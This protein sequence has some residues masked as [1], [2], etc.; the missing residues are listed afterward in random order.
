MKFSKE[1][2]E[3]KNPAIP[4]QATTDTAATASDN[5]WKKYNNETVWLYKIEG[6]SPDQIWATKKVE[7]DGTVYKLNNPKYAATVKKLDASNELPDRTEESKAND[8]VLKT[9]AAKPAADK[10]TAPDTRL[11]TPSELDTSNSADDRAGTESPG[12]VEAVSKKATTTL[13]TIKVSQEDQ[14]LV[15]LR[16]AAYEIDFLPAQLKPDYENQRITTALMQHVK[17]ETPNEGQNKSNEDLAKMILLRDTD[18]ERS[19]LSAFKD[20]G[21]YAGILKA[22]S[23]LKKGFDL[24]GQDSEYPNGFKNNLLNALARAFGMNPSNYAGIP[25]KESKVTYGKSHA[26]LLRERYWG[27]Y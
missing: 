23:D 8:P 10:K 12:G 18:L 26:T 24:E 7:G 13:P 22:M 11:A 19:Q 21:N 3:G 15:T 25:L 6:N 17:R 27:R 20:E 5:E 9:P 4:A 1:A 16:M 2:Q 14:D